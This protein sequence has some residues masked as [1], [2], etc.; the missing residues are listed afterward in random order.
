MMRRRVI[1]PALK[2]LREKDNMEIN[3]E[4][5]KAGRKV[6]DLCFTFQPNPQRK[7]DL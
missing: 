7:L 1:E 3:L 4:L 2:E 5:V 6:T